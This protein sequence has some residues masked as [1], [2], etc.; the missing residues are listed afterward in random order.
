MCVRGLLNVTCVCAHGLLN[1]T[2]NDISVIRVTAHRCAGGLKKLDLR[3]DSHAIDLNVPVQATT[4]GH[5]FYGYSM[6]LK[7]TGS[8]SPYGAKICY[9]F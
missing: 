6:D 4:P 8:L 9:T 3:S 1:V 2:F 5:H 7:E